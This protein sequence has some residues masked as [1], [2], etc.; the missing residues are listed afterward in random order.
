MDGKRIVTARRP[1]QL[2]KENPCARDRARPTAVTVT[3]TPS[4]RT[5]TRPTGGWPP[6]FSARSIDSPNRGTRCGPVDRP[7]R[8]VWTASAVLVESLALAVDLPRLLRPPGYSRHR[9]RYPVG[10]LFDARH[11]ALRAARGRARSVLKSPQVLRTGDYKHWRSVVDNANVLLSGTV[12]RLCR[13]ATVS[14]PVGGV[15]SGAGAPGWPSIYAAYLGT[16]GGPPVPCSALLRVGFA[17]P[18]RSPG[19]LVRSYRTVSPLP[20][21]PGGPVGHRRSVLCGTFL[22]VAPTGR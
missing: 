7:W 5:A 18:P 13:R 6:H 21:P 11:V 14:R 8:A 22:R 19:A 12:P 10:A 4:S 20:V 3:T 9:A 15:L 16:S 2:R 17:E 1:G